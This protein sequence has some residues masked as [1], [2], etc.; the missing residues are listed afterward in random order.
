MG[1]RPRIGCGAEVTA[2]DERVRP[3]MPD[4]FAPAKRKLTLLL[5][6]ASAVVGAVG[7]FGVGIDDNAL[8]ILLV[9]LSGACLAAAFVHPIREPARFRRAF[10]RTLLVL[11]VLIALAFAI[12]TIG[13]VLRPA[14]SAEEG[15]L[16]A[17][18]IYVLVAASLVGVPALCVLAVG[19]R[20]ARS[21]E[22]R[23]SGE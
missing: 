15:V 22:R 23:A 8:G 21:R 19:G 20:I 11:V 14:G 17:V 13:A 16:G 2:A 3:P 12:E 5:L 7:W 18:A 9:A 4:A 6:A 1:P 10:N